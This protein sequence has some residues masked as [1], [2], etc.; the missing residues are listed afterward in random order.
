MTEQNAQ[1]PPVL[2]RALKAVLRP[3]VK[4]M[5]ARG[6][7]AP[8]AY[9]LLKEVYVES[10]EADFSE[11]RGARPTD[12]RISVLTGI[13][14]RDV[15]ALRG[16]PDEN[17]RAAARRV[18]T[19]A[20]VVG[21]WLADPALA[22]SGAPQPLPR[23]ADDGP[24]FDGLVAAV[25]KDVRPRT[26]LDAMESQGLVIVEGHGSAAHI[27]LTAAA[28][29]APG[30]ADEKLVFYGRNLGDHVSAATENLL[31]DPAPFFERAVFYNR[32]T[33]NSVE[34]LEKEAHER[35]MTLLTDLNARAFAL[36]E[37][38]AGNPAAT[39][40]FRLGVYVYHA[41]E[42]PDSQSPPDGAGDED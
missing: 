25:S 17:R 26:V 30:A 33:Q 39:E 23:T 38:D 35:G 7:T 19:L 3:L 31:T 20:T 12:S 28:V 29:V 13:H 42:E 34:A 4:M 37:K 5:I 6:V 2:D 10:A 32:L 15:K 1:D 36:Q 41:T 27:A 8:S 24:S 40:R 18:T 11:E 16:G 21:R 14:R 9:R 22:P